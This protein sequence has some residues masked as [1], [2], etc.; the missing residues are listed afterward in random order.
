MATFLAILASIAGVVGVLLGV[1]LN[2]FVRRKNRRELYAPKIFEKRLAAYENLAELIQNGSKVAN[3]VIENP[4][5]TT[6]QRHDVIGAVVVSIA[7]SMDK[8]LLYIDKEPGAYCAALF[9]GVE[10]FYAAKEEEKQRLLRNY[11]G[12]RTEAL[13]MISEDSGVA[14]IKKLFRTINRPKI[15]G[16]IVGAIRELRRR[17]HRTGHLYAR[18]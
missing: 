3:E 9:M 15:G 18:K 11:Y 12:M 14:E 4:D 13:R 5:L 2:E 16:P 1:L 10:N 7:K 17:Q 6:E 8:D